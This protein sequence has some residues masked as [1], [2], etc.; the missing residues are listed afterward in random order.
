MVRI[1]STNYSSLDATIDN[2]QTHTKYNFHSTHPYLD[3]S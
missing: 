2:A 1:R 3:A